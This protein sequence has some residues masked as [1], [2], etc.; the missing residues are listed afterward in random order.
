MVKGLQ[1]SAE[2][3]PSSVVPQ[4]R[5]WTGAGKLQGSRVLL[6]QYYQSWKDHNGEGISRLLLSRSV[7]AK[8]PTSADPSTHL[9]FSVQL[10]SPF[11]KAIFQTSSALLEG[12]MNGE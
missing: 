12:G 7:Q 10:L 9:C 6:R 3:D 8:A 11:L 4:D 2:V 5:S 1:R